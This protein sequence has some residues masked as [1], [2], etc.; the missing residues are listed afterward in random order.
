M[1]L[2]V[3]TEI[4]KSLKVCTSCAEKRVINRECIRFYVCLLRFSIQVHS[5]CRE[6][7]KQINR[8]NVMQKALPSDT[9]PS[10][11]RREILKEGTNFPL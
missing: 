7:F 6:K 11:S 1:T 4:T 3:L 8:A 5:V 9:K 10:K 2:R